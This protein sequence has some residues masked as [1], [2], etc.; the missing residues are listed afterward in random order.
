MREKRA[1]NFEGIFSQ[2]GQGNISGL[3]MFATRGEIYVSALQ[4]M[5]NK[6]KKRFIRATSSQSVPS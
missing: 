5:A 3:S 4:H 6:L 2:L 1:V